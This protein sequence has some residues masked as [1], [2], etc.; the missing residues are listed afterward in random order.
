MDIRL[1]TTKELA[2]T[3]ELTQ[4]YLRYLITTGSIKGFKVNRDWVVEDQEARRWLQS[5]GI[6]P[7]KVKVNS[8]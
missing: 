6:N 5:R 7:G 2:N 4:A 8:S 1:W 3:A